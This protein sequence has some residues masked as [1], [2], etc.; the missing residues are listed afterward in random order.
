[1]TDAFCAAGN[2]AA[3]IHGDLASETRKGHPRRL[4]VRAV[5]RVI[6]NV[7]VLSLRA[8]IIRPTS[9][10]RVCCAPVFL[11]SPP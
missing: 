1:V 7:A 11:Q 4:R 2:H 5:F 10:C 8:G 6:V 3:L 9:L